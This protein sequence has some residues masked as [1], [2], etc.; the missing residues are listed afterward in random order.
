MF[1]QL[2]PEQVVTFKVFLLGSGRIRMRRFRAC[3][4]C[5]RSGISGKGEQQEDRGFRLLTLFFLSMG[6][7]R[8]RMQLLIVV[9]VI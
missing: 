6:I 1:S 2:N 9:F 5:F 4:L 8:G 7:P 3:N